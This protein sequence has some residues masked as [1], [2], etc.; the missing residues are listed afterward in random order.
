MLNTATG[1]A[2]FSAT[3]SAI[4]LYSLATSNEP[5]AYPDDLEDNLAITVSM[6]VPIWGRKNAAGISEKEWQAKGVRHAKRQRMLAFQKRAAVLISTASDGKRR[7][8][9]YADTL[10]PQARD[11]YQSILSQYS[12]DTNTTTFLDVLSATQ[13]ILEFQL[14][15]AKA[16][17]DWR[18]AQAELCFLV[19]RP[20]E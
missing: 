17:R 14:N 4:D 8:G 9:L 15:K 1:A 2:P 16:L 20:P 13:T 19:A 6:N 18:I 10:I 7:H 5:M 3:S 12:A 11:T